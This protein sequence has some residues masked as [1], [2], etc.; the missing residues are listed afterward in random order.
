MRSES[1]GPYH[2]DQIIWT[3]SYGPDHTGH[4]I[5]TICENLFLFSFHIWHFQHS[6]VDL[7]RMH[8][9]FVRHFHRH[10]ISHSSHCMPTL[11]QIYHDWKLFCCHR[12]YENSVYYVLCSHIKDWFHMHPGHFN[13]FQI[14]GHK[15]LYSEQ[16]GQTRPWS[17]QTGRGRW[18]IFSS[19]SVSRMN[20]YEKIN[21]NQP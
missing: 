19:M 20:L 9:N 11:S 1:Y 10:R 17:D 18:K 7:I 3:V 13:S 15:I 12:M 16:S 14:F 4:I 5:W 6:H 8:D 2:M 21:E